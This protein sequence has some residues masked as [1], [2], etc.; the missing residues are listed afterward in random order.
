MENQFNKL[1]SMP[2]GILRMT[3]TVLLELLLLLMIFGGGCEGELFACVLAVFM[4]E[5]ETM[6]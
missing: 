4:Y 3:T 6:K 2:F 5:R 1:N